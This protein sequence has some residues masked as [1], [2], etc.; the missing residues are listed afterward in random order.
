MPQIIN[1]N[2]ASLSAQRNLDKSQ[3]ANST[4]LERLSSGLRINSAKDDAAG[5]AI[6]TRFESQTRGLNVA[7]RNAGDGVSLAQTAEGALGSMTDSLQRIRELAVQSAN[8]TNSDADRVALQAEATQLIEEIG[9]VAD[10]TN[11]NGQKLLDGSFSAQFQ[12]GANAGEN[13]QFSVAEVSTSK[14]GAGQESGISALGTDEAFSN[15]DL[16]ING[17]GISASSA[18]DDTSSTAGAD[19]SAIAKAAAINKHS[20]DTGVTADVNTNIAAGTKQEA[21][22]TNG[23]ITLNGTKVD[24][25]TGGVDTSADRASVLQAINS[26]SNQTGVTA[27][28]TGEDSTGINLVAED[29][30]NIEIRFDKFDSDGNTYANGVTAAATGLSNGGEGAAGAVATS[31]RVEGASSVADI[32]GTASVGGSFDIA[33]D[34]EEAISVT[35]SGTASSVD[36][37]VAAVQASI[38]SAISASNQNV[39]VTVGSTNNILTITSNSTGEGSS[40]KIDNAATGAAEID[41]MDLFGLTNYG[42]DALTVAAA[43]YLED[44]GTTGAENSQ[45]TYTGGHGMLTNAGA[46]LGVAA[47]APTLTG[48]DVDFSI[49]I[50]GGNAVAVAITV[51]AAAFDTVSDLDNYTAVLETEINNALSAD[52]QSGRVDVSYDEGYRLTITSR[53]EGSD[54]SVL[55]SGSDA[56]AQANLGLASST[57]SITPLDG[58]VG[59]DGVNNASDVY[60]GS[61]TLRSTNGEDINITSGSGSLESTGL[62]SG[63]FNASEAYVSSS[64]REVSGSI[65]SNAEVIGNRITSG[66]IDDAAVVDAG[67]TL[68]GVQFDIAVDGGNAVSVDFTATTSEITSAENYL[69]A[70]EADINASLAA[71]G[72]SATVELSL[73]DDKQL[74]I[75][76]NSVG[77]SSSI[78]LSQVAS[79]H[80][81]EEAGSLGLRNFVSSGDDGTT[82]N[83]STLTSVGSTDSAAAYVGDSFATS[84]EQVGGVLAAET[85]RISVDGGK[86]I[87]VDIAN[88]TVT[89]TDSA[90]SFVETTINDAL[91]DAGQSATVDLALNTDGFVTITSD[92]VGSGSS[93]E[94]VDANSSVASTFSSLAGVV[95]FQKSNSVSDGV[96]AV[97]GLDS[98]DLLINGTAIEGSLASD[99]TASNSEALSSD[100]AASGIAVAAAINRASDQTGVTATVNATSL[101]GGSQVA[102]STSDVSQQGSIIVNGV[103]TSKL[104]TTGANGG[105]DD[106]TAAI[107]AINAIAGQTGVIAIDDGE[108]I[109]LEASDGRNISAV[110]NN[111]AKE[112]ADSNGSFEALDG[113]S[114]GLNIASADISAGATFAATAQTSYSTVSLSSAGQISVTAGENGTAALESLGLREGD[115]GSSEAGT[116]V[117]DIDISSVEGANAAIKAIDNALDT[118]AGERAKLGAVQNRLDTTVSNLAVTS[119]NLT[120]ANSRI[121]DADFAT[122]SAELSRTQVLQQAGISILAQANQRGQQVL[123]LIG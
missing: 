5:L 90:L 114:L 110:I 30:R 116:R 52:G 36:E 108:G 6:S 54:S 73:N 86:T 46:T 17:Q 89:D 117:A 96:E 85:I 82:A 71:D 24:I 75:K 53:E 92:K 9:R 38:D 8:A 113:A 3:S 60:E 106:R 7:I 121:R 94:I 21:A 22:A 44:T 84:L 118:V 12:V 70:L 56:H 49:A 87:D 77:A 83:K 65:A 47:G 68:A 67:L 62:A 79:S 122:E 1:T 120:A 80:T 18:T 119:E 93:V 35:L 64:S 97:D 31:A 63:S 14:L 78:E 34:G 59:V 95:D 32:A 43:V 105:A 107:D 20:E 72:Q 115:Y 16:V 37:V 26:V 4:A 2:I 40:I 104:T 66:G 55:V 91:S 99:D 13:L 123:S 98:G 111:N 15:G 41:A 74:S 102:R 69:T 23:S 57:T 25:T 76:S 42:N 81:S 109:T 19:R 100:K 10:E 112:A 88:H 11:F 51:Q 58:A 45:A 103:E 27:V 28:D 101:N 61:I 33:I 48:A 50:D 39:G 29:G